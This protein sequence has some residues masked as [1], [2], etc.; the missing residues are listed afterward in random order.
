MVS[1]AFQGDLV[2]SEP[3]ALVHPVMCEYMEYLLSR[4]GR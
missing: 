1:L 2:A 3:I 4:L